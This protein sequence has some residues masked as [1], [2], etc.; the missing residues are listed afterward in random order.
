VFRGGGERNTFEGCARLFI[1][2][3]VRSDP[4]I[5]LEIFEDGPNVRIVEAT[6]T[7][8]ELDLIRGYVKESS[9]LGSRP[10]RLIAIPEE[11]GQVAGWKPADLSALK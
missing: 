7:I 2:P 8:E 3:V 10:K 6:S 1:E 11:G 4:E 5:S 9:A